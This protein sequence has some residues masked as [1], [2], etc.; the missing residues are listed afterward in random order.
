[1]TK[2]LSMPVLPLGS[3]AVRSTV[4]AVL[5]VVLTVPTPFTRVIGLLSKDAWPV[6]L[7]SVT[8]VALF[9]VT[10]LLNWSCAVTVSGKGLGGILR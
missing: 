2:P 6:L 4:S 10:G 3:L 7:P 5:S 9:V 8:G 1:M